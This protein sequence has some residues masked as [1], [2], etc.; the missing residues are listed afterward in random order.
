LAA[1]VGIAA[2]LSLSCWTPSFD[3]AISV[4]AGL[5]RKLEPVMTFEPVEMGEWEYR[6]GYFIP[7]RALVPT[8]G[9]WVKASDDGLNIRYAA[10]LSGKT[11]LYPMQS[12][13]YNT[14]GTAASV[15]ALTQ[16]SALGL[17]ALGRGLLL[18]FSAYGEGVQA[19]G[20]DA[21]YGFS[22]SANATVSGAAN[23]RMVGAYRSPLDAAT[24][25]LAILHYDTTDGKLWGGYAS[26]DNAGAFSAPSI[27]LSNPSEYGTMDLLSGAFFGFGTSGYYLSGRLAS[28]GKLLTIRWSTDLGGTATILSGVDRQL[29]DLLYDGRLLARGGLTTIVYDADGTELFEIPT[30]DMRFI[31]EIYDGTIWYSYFTRSVLIRLS[32]S[33]DGG[34]LAIEVF[35]IPTSAL[36]TLAK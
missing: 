29:T 14:L 33:Y 11:A 19:R 15:S 28:D 22:L 4:S 34:K 10:S 2:T 3:P 12:I 1:A 18:A 16:D 32:G 6:D 30:G 23:P 8:D 20:L 35:R 25:A 24:D 5:E 36:E 26:I 13:G 7:H 31:H 9:Y 27:A 17:S 21:S